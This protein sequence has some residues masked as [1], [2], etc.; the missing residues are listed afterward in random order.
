VLD[1]K[2]GKYIKKMKW[3]NLGGGHHIT[4]PDYDVETL[5]SVL[6]FSRTSME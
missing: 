1:E 6:C 2:F 5:I 3:L 4:R